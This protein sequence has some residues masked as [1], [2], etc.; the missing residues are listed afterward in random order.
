MIWH[1]GDM[2]LFDEPSR[3]P[4]PQPNFEDVKHAGRK[5]LIGMIPFVGGAGS[6][7]IG[8]LSSPVAQRRDD[9]FEDLQ[10]RLQ[11]L[12]GKVD[13]FKFEDLAQNEQ[14]VSATLQATQSALRTHQ[15]EKLEALRNAVLNVA[16]GIRS[17]ADRQEQFLALVDR[18]TS[19]HLV[20]LNL[21]RD[22][23]G[24]C[25]SHGRNVPIARK[26]THL[27]VYQVLDSA[28]PLAASPGSA[29]ALRELA[30]D[31]LAAVRLIR[32]KK[33]NDKWLM[34]RS[35]PAIADEEVES[36]TTKLG[37][38]FLDFISAPEKNG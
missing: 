33:E 38:D 2:S 15:Q 31:E 1:N 26:G 28:M 25:R 4:V 5:S 23:A 22:P 6:E 10:R 20:L 8:L 16:S 13:G 12:E 7:L 30:V 3:K 27:F 36:A 37:N 19:E 35:H 17:Y 29:G 18:F 21:F 32:L 34:P 14:F 24:Y 9:W 11:N